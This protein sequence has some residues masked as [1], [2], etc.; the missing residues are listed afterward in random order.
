MKR[1]RPH[2]ALLSAFAAAA[3][4][5]DAGITQGTGAGSD[6]DASQASDVSGTGD[7]GPI[8]GTDT[9]GSDT[10]WGGGDDAT[11]A[12]EPEDV[13]AAPDGAPGVGEFGY[14]C[15][16]N[17]DCLSGYCVEGVS[18]TVCTKGCVEDCPQGWGCK[19]VQNTGGDVTFICLYNFVNLCRPCASNA[20]C[21]AAG[22]LAVGTADLCL[23]YSAEGRFCGADC[24]ENACPPGFTCSDVEMQPGKV[25]KQCVP[26]SGMCE[27]EPKYD[28]HATTCF[29]QNGFGKCSGTRSCSGGALTECNAPIPATET[30]DGKDNDCD[31]L[32]DEDVP[33]QTCE[34][35]NEFGTCG[36]NAT[37]KAGEMVCNAKDAQIEICD[38][39]DNDCDGKVDEDF[40]DTDGDGKSDC[41]DSDDDGDG[42]ND[43]QDNCPLVPNP[44]QE[45]Y[46]LDGKG[47]ACDPDDD[48]DLVKD[49]DDCEPYNPLAYPGA[50]ELCD[51]IDNN[52][53]GQVD[54]GFQDLD[55]DGKKDC[56]D[57]DDDNDGVPDGLDN[58]PTIVNPDQIDT[59]LDG[60]G[61]ECDPDDDNDTIPDEQDNC[62]KTPNLDQKDSNGDG[63]GDACAEDADGDG[64]K[65]I[66]DNCPL[67]WNPDQS[68][69]DSDGLG[70]AC[71]DDD[72]GDGVPDAIDNCK[73]VK[74]PAQLD[75]DKD[76]LGDD[77]DPDDDNDGVP[78]D[79]DNCKLVPNPDQVDTDGDG[80]GNACDLDDDGDGSPDTVDCMPLDPSIHPNAPEICNEVDDNCNGKIDEE[81]SEACSKYY[82][83]GDGDGWGTAENKCLCNGSGKFTALNTGDCNDTDTGVNPGQPEI[84]GDGKDQNCNG[85]ENDDN[86]VGCTPYYFDGDGDGFGTSDTIC[87]CTASGKHT[88]TKTGDCNDGDAGINPGIVE[89]CFNGKDDNCNGDQN[90][91][92]AVGCTPYYQDADKDG[93]G[94]GTA[95]CF[96]EPKGNFTATVAGD[97]VDGDPAVKPTAKEVCGSGK[98]DNC[99]G[100]QNE[101]GA[102]GCTTYYYDG[103]KDGY[104]TALSKC[105]CGPVDPYLA[106]QSGDCLD[107]NGA[108]NPGAKEACNSVDDDCSGA[109]DDAPIATLCGAPAN[110]TVACAGSCSITS[111]KAPYANMNGQYNDGCE[112]ASDGNDQAGAGNAC[113]AAIHLGTFADN[114]SL[115][116]AGGNIV[117]AG[118]SDWYSMLTQDSADSTCDKF[119]VRARFTYNPG[120]QFAFDVYRGGCAGGNAICAASTDFDW[121]TNFSAGGKGEC[122]CAPDPGTTNTNVCTDNSAWFY[123]RVFRK[124]NAPLS[125]DNYEIEVTNAVY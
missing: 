46:D 113:A 41:L 124:D 87:L 83:D 123:I 103:D 59:D 40:P 100:T 69:L 36:G 52:C 114:G 10:T 57:P 1:F 20:D 68:D 13:P 12:G 47:D 101:E 70:D 98:D 97:C 84:C 16:S 42:V 29:V 37:C 81:G 80:Q 31:G 76:G 102:L 9:S 25:Q 6:A 86:A 111:C 19:S 120:N 88:A 45:D 74:N 93:F 50:L 60:K 24:S 78:D 107:S 116:V 15:K 99:N 17:A 39:V 125:C 54:E 121:Y 65:N 105:L 3:A 63:V 43:L 61:D 27:C 77:C 82:F 7:A 109:P 67:V 30:C 89:V 44:G 106:T 112:C 8:W 62:P 85:T 94:T 73:L 56:V 72:D 117:P 5:T 53:N 11:D 22:G 92:N 51:G 75:F 64:V 26:D 96:C 21:A 23:D 49:E 33:T 119:K 18:S 34:K 71:D 79:V 28:G 95:Q 48:N 91:L 104:G 110:A 4:C 108:I 32:T 90:D 38:S 58:C 35:T 118:D 55:G 66:N 115:K 14:E 2:L 122:P